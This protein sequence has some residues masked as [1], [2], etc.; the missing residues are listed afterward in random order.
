MHKLVSILVFV[1]CNTG[2]FSL[3]QLVVDQITAICLSLIDVLFDIVLKRPVSLKLAVVNV[4]YKLRI[5]ESI[6]LLTSSCCLGLAVPIGLSNM[7][8]HA[9]SLCMQYVHVAI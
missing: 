2:C 5:L 8:S 3:L 7:E 6:V 1:S 4:M 9:H